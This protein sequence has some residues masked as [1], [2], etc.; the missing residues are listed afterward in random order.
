MDIEKTTSDLQKINCSPTCTDASVVTA[1]K[2]RKILCANRNRFSLY[3]YYLRKLGCL[4]ANLVEGV[5]L[6]QGRALIKAW[7]LTSGNTV[8]MFFVVVFLSVV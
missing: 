2:I 6:I 5:V 3:L 4:F 8:C 7:A 1:Y